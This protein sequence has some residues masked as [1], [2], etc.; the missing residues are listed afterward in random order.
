M[1]FGYAD[2]ATEMRLVMY[3]I[4]GSC[5]ISVSVV[6]LVVDGVMGRG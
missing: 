4:V 6:E 1:E 3:D 5:S 2:A